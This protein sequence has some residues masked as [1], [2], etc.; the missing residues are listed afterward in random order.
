MSAG[1]G[2]LIA[3][4]IA[5]RSGRILA[6]LQQST[7]AAGEERAAG[8]NPPAVVTNPTNLG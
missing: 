7:I 5:V 3:H 6:S 2:L 4:F 1:I 8:G